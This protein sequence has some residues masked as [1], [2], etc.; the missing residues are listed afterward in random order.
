MRPLFLLCGLS[1]FALL[2]LRGVAEG[3]DIPPVPSDYKSQLPPPPGLPNQLEIPVN[4][5]I[6]I[7]VW[8]KTLLS[9]PPQPNDPRLLWSPDLKSALIERNQSDI[10]A[11][12]YWEGGRSSEAYVIRGVSFNQYSAVYPDQ[13]NISGGPLGFSLTRRAEG[14]SNTAF[15]GTSWYAPS[16]YVGI[17]ALGA[18]LA[19]NPVLV[20]VP[21]GA[22]TP[23]GGFPAGVSLCLDAKTLLPVRLDDGTFI[24]AFSC[25]PASDVRIDPQGAFLSAIQQQFGNW[26]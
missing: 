9:P 17:A 13:I 23:G 1:I 20:F 25:Y 15:P 24:Y 4:T 7:K 5:R 2:P 19:A 26:P 18:G 10:H 3:A 6:A 14:S 8:R 22:Q 12:F 21:G 11:V 16:C